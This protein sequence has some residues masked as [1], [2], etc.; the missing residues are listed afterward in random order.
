MGGMSQEAAADAD[1][2]EEEELGPLVYSQDGSWDWPLSRHEKKARVQQLERQM[3]AL[4]KKTL[5]EELRRGTSCSD[6]ESD[7][8]A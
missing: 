3:Y 4:D 2:E 7:D 6:S 8:C 5:L 1:S